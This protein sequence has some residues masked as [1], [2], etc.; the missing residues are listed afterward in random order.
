MLPDDRG[1]RRGHRPGRVRR[2]RG[3]HAAVPGGR[4]LPE[5]RRGQEPQEHQRAHGHPA[6]LRQH[7]G[8]GRHA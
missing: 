8:R 5:L 7:R 4:I 6:R 2:G 3:G 1:N